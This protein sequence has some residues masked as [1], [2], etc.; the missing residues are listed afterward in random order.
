ML[1]GV[2]IGIYK[3]LEEAKKYF[4]KQKNTAYPDDSKNAIY[5]KYYSAYRKLYNAVRPIV[6]E[7]NN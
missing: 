7:A 1:A 4:V 3:D 6:E 5:A 2:G